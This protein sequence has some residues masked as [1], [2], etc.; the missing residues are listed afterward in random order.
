MIGG[1]NS[2]IACFF[3]WAEPWQVGKN[4]KAASSASSFYAMNYL[5]Q[6]RRRGRTNSQSDQHVTF[7]YQNIAIGDYGT[8]GDQNMV[9]RPLCQSGA[10]SRCFSGHRKTIYPA[11]AKVQ[12]PTGQPREPHAKKYYPTETNE[13]SHKGFYHSSS[14]PGIALRLLNP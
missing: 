8:L 3:Y 7:R 11:V 14:P 1:R 12:P 2:L 9:G 5:N 6:A 13:K 10:G 4:T